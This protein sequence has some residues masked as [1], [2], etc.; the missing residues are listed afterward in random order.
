MAH[1]YIGH[2]QPIPYDIAL[3]AELKGEWRDGR[4]WAQVP[5]VAAREPRTEAERPFSWTHEATPEGQ[6]VVGGLWPW[7]RQGWTF[8]DAPG[9]MPDFG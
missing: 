2:Y 3:L 1:F 5:A 7:M 6:G 8:L 9:A 4:L